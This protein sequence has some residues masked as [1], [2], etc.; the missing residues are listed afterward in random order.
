MFSSESYVG[1]SD[2]YENGSSGDNN[3]DDWMFDM[4]R[5][6][7][8]SEELTNPLEKSNG[9]WTNSSGYV[10]IRTVYLYIHSCLVIDD[11]SIVTIY[12]NNYM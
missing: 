2:V 5:K 6:S 9:L 4:N 3:S 12:I 8:D 11:Y 7:R 1:Q 10:H